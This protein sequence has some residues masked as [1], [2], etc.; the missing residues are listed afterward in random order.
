MSHIRGAKSFNVATFEAVT[1]LVNQEVC[2]DGKSFL[3]MRGPSEHAGE[4]QP[5]SLVLLPLR[6]VKVTP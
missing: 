6:A 2:I 4:C 5:F 3:V 1:A